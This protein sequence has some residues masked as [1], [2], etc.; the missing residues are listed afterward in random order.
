L[1]Q[2]LAG[3]LQERLLQRQGHMRIGQ[4]FLGL[5]QLPAQPGRFSHLVSVLHAHD[6][7]VLATAPLPH[8]AQHRAVALDGEL[9]LHGRG[10]QLP[11]FDLPHRLHFEGV[12]V[13][14]DFHDSW[15]LHFKVTTYF[16]TGPI[17]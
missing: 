9:A 4:R 2:L 12:T 13:T 10:A 5:A 15:L 8:P 3:H 1:V 14:N 17:H 6:L 7:A 16:R 11:G